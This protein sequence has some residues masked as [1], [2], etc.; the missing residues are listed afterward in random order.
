MMPDVCGSV[1]DMAHHVAFYHL[2]E[3]QP[4]RGPEPEIRTI[5]DTMRWTITFDRER[6]VG[7]EECLSEFEDLVPCSLSR[8][9]R[10]RVTFHH[11][12]ESFGLG[13]MEGCEGS[14]PSREDLCQGSFSIACGSL[15]LEFA[16]C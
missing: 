1:F 10:E 14:Y 4:L 5:M 15:S 7:P 8:S 16:F 12:I 3:L 11:H 9:L 13:V 6:E 2:R